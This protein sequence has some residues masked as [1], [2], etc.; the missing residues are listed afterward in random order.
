M[1]LLMRSLD[2]QIM[3]TGGK[4]IWGE[5]HCSHIKM[6]ADSSKEKNSLNFHSN[7]MT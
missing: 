7:E 4:R 3:K 5:L 1:G 6:I 2:V